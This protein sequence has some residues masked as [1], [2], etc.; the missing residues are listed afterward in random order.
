MPHIGSAAEAASQ[1]QFA[2]GVRGT[3]FPSLAMHMWRKI[4]QEGQFSRA[5][6]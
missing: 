6:R 4:E 1:L 3:V 5:R 2:Q